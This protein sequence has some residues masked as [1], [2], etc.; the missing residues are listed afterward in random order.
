MS[1]NTKS[2][3]TKRTQKKVLSDKINT[4][5]L[6]HKTSSGRSKKVTCPFSSVVHHTEYSR[7][8]VQDTAVGVNSNG[9]G[10]SRSKVGKKWLD[11]LVAF[12]H[13][14]PIEAEQE[15]FSGCHPVL[16]LLAIAVEELQFQ[17]LVQ[18]H[19]AS[20]PSPGKGD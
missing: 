9:S 17:A 7:L 16:S 20:D 10:K 12:R 5:V 8:I 3:Y 19:A 4:T 13:A 1:H 2:L 6:L 14:P 11:E 18:L 15:S